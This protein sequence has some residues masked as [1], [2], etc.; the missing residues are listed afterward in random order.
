MAANTAPIYSIKGDN[1]IDDGN[2][3]TSTLL[4]ATGDYTGASANHVLVFTSDAADGGYIARLRFKALG[5][6]VATCARVYINNG[7]ANTT[8]ANNILYGEVSLPAITATNTAA[9]SDIDY[10]M[11]FALK[12]GFR[13]YVGLATT[14]ASGWKVTPIGGQYA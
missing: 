7:G 12:A 3:L 8:A 6:N 13:I 14:V 11:A 4:T 2:T 9:T 10:P 5:T 1:S